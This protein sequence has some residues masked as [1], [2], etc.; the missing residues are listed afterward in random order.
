MFIVHFET[1]VILNVVKVF[2]VH[3]TQEVDNLNSGNYDDGK[4]FVSI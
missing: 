4:A 3:V 1:Q 2:W